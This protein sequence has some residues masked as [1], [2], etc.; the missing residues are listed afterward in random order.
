[1]RSRPANRI[2]SRQLLKFDLRAPS[3]SDVDSTIQMYSDACHP[4]LFIRIL[5]KIFRSTLFCA[6]LLATGHILH[7]AGQHFN[8]VITAATVTIGESKGRGGTSY[9]R[10]PHFVQFL[11]FSSRYQ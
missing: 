11:S 7:H 1:M 2:R 9:P 3:S 10:P 5:R 8:T 4:A 6:S